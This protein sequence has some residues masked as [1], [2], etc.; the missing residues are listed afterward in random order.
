MGQSIKLRYTLVFQKREKFIKKNFRPS[1]SLEYF[2]FVLSLM[3]I[4]Q[5]SHHVTS[6]NFQPL[7]EVI[8]DVAG[9]K[10]RNYKNSA[11]KIIRPNKKPV[12]IAAE[13]A[14]P[15]HTLYRVIKNR[16]LYDGMYGF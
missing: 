16:H 11:Y 10:S 3:V 6:D 2:H 15:L 9:V 12:Y 7:E 14:T 8:K 5:I 1:L 13:C 4:S